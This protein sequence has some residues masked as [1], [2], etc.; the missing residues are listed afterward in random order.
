MHEAEFVATYAHRKGGNRF[1]ALKVAKEEELAKERGN[2]WTALKIAKEKMA[3]E[4]E[5]Q[6][7]SAGWKNK[8]LDGMQLN[9]CRASGTARGVTVKNAIRCKK[10]GCTF[11][12]ASTKVV[13]A[14]M[15]EAHV[16]W[17]ECSEVG[18]SYKSK[19]AE[20]LERHKR[21]HDAT[22][23]RGS[24]VK[25]EDE[26]ILNAVFA[27]KGDRYT[28]CSS[29]K[30]WEEQAEVMPMLPDENGMMGFKLG[31]TGEGLR[32]R[33]AF[34]RKVHLEPGYAVPERRPPK[35]W[36]RTNN[37]PKGWSGL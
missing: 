19:R 17:H 2:P 15:A 23:G 37:P 28:T 3:K 33:H 20:D 4:K 7:R 18:C 16:I 35:G 13:I 6:A 5:L 26:W 24:W 9:E 14:H 8:C 34:L 32:G 31:L 29:L 21:S 11:S 27:E 30:F 12:H 10:D 36:S 25:A 1:T 22:R